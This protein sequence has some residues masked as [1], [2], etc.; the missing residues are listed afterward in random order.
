MYDS[1]K[2][3]KK[4]VD[5]MK[6]S[7]TSAL[8]VAV[9]TANV[10]IQ[11]FAEDIMLNDNQEI[12][13]ERI[14][15]KKGDLEID[16]N[17]ELPVKNVSIS[18]TNIKVQ[19]KKDDNVITEILLGSGSSRG[20]FEYDNAVYNY[21]INRLNFDR[22]SEVSENNKVYNYRIC[23]KDLP[24][25]ESISYG[26]EVIGNGFKTAKIDNIELNNY[27]KRVIMSNI[28][29]EDKNGALLFGD[30]NGDGIVNEDDYNELYSNLKTNKSK[31]DL[32]RDGKVNVT[33]LSYIHKNMNNQ[34]GESSIEDTNAI[35]DIENIEV[36]VSDGATVGQTITGNAEDLFNDNGTV[37][38]QMPED[39]TI[40]EETPAKL[41][42]DLGVKHK[43]DV[44]MEQI[45][46]KGGTNAPRTGSVE[47]NGQIYEFGKEQTT[48]STTGSSD[49]VIDLNGQIPVSKITINVTG[50]T[51]D[52]NLVDIAKVE[53]LNN[54]YKEIPKPEMALPVIN[55]VVTSTQVAHE[56]MEIT[57][58]RVQNVTGY[59]VK[60]ETIND[61]GVVQNTR[62]FRTSEERLTVR[63]IKAYG[64]YRIS[65]QSLNG[66]WQGGYK[67][68]EPDDVDG[69]PDNIVKESIASGTYQIKPIERDSIVEI[70]VVPESKPD[71]PEGIVVESGYK[72]LDVSW[73]SHNSAQSFDVYYR[74][75]GENEA[76]DFTKAN[77]KPI[78]NTTKYTIGGLKDGVSYEVKMTATNHLGTS[79]MSKGYV[80]KTTEM[81]IPKSPNYKLINTPTGENT[82]TSHI[83]SVEFPITAGEGNTD[84]FDE[85]CVV[86]NDY[87]TAWT[88]NDWDA[89]IYNKRGP[90]VT[91]DKEYE[92]DTIALIARLDSV[93]SNPYKA[94]IGVWNDQTNEWE[95][96]E[97]SVINK[98]ENG[99]YTILK[100]DKPITGKKIQVNT[101]VYGTNKVS[102]A[103]IKFYNYDSVEHDIKALF[104]D[105]LQIELRKSTNVTQSEIDNLRERLN[106]V[107]P[108]SKEYHPDRDTLLKELQLAEDLL[109]DKE[110]SEKVITIDPLINKSGV[111]TGYNN[112]WQA[113][114][115]SAKAGDTINVYLAS[116]ENRNIN[117]AYEQH[118]GESG[119]FISKEI[120]LK[121]GKNTIQL[122]KLHDINVEKGGNLYVRYPRNVENSNAQ[123]KIR[124]SGATQIPHLNL[125]NHLEDVNTLVNNKDNAS[126]EKVAEI[127]AMLKEYIE[128][129]KV[130]VNGL[131]DMY[132]KNATSVDNLNNVYSYDEKT[133][134]L[135]TTNIEGDR[136]TLTL[137]ATEV[138]EGITKDIEGDI[139][140][141]VD[142]L[143]DTVLAWEQIIQVTN[144]KKGVYERLNDFNGSGEIDDDD[145]A[146]YNSNK[147]SKSRVNVKYQRMFI[148]AFMYASGHHIGVDTGSSVGL[149]QGVPFK[150]DENGK[151]TNPDEGKLFGW[152]ISHEIGHK[153]DTPGRVYNET[154]NNILALI[155]QT[156]DGIDKSR[157][158]ENDTYKKIYER[159]TSGSVGTPQDISVL[160]GMFW[161]LHLAYEPG[162][163]SQMLINNSDNNPDNDSFY[164]KLNRAYRNTPA[165][166]SDKDQLLIRRASDAAGKDLRGFFASWGLIADESTSIYLQQKFPNKKETR[167]IQYLNDN[168]YRKRLDGV[169]SIASDTEVEASFVGT[170]NNSVVNSD[171]IT[172]DLNVN[173]DKDKILG[174]EII[175]SDGNYNEDGKTKVS[176]K[177]V[178]FVEA[179]EDGSATFT[180]SIAPLNNRALTYKVIAYDYNLNPTAEYEVGSVKLSHDGR[181][182]SNKFILKSNLTS[183]IEDMTLDN[184]KDGDNTTSFKGR[185]ITKD[186]YNNDPHKEEGIDVNADPYIIMDLNGSKDICGIKYI[187]SDDSVSKFSLKKL[188]ARNSSYSAIDK[189]EIH[190]SDD[191]KTWTKVSEGSFNFGENSVL[192]GANGE[193]IAKVLF[194]NGTDLITYNTKYVKLVA[195]G[196][197]NIDIADIEL[198]GGTGD[199]IEIGA[200][201]S[202]DNTRTNG[203][204]RLDKEFV[205]Q[206]DNEETTDTDEEIVIPEG[207]IV[208]TGEYKGNP[209]FNIPLLIDEKNNTI[210]GE[211]ILMANV[212]EDAPL[213]SVS[214]GKW[215]YWLSEDEYD[216]LTNKVKAELY[217]YNELVDDAPIGQRLVSDTLYVDVPGD[218]YNELPSISLEN[219]GVYVK[220]KSINTTKVIYMDSKE[221]EAIKETLR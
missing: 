55:N 53:F 10:P 84:I 194:S 137:P 4:G 39:V 168:A 214:S 32:N 151:V 154:T 169:E 129:L 156:F 188:F 54:V 49:I 148:G 114:G 125:N 14:N 74:E 160:L 198:I 94:N 208:I 27:S 138:Y 90:I 186:E 124:V 100:L 115:F 166:T 50:T 183:D 159:V 209:A 185:K 9:V 117:L 68:A 44:V 131:P 21:T 97:A 176:Y 161:Q 40:S 89:S 5:Y 197:K 47:V 157:L 88:I 192:G 58:D 195:V 52:R 163:T 153:A 135:N 101:S 179:K 216:S 41:D 48:R 220:S 7:I 62:T 177:P 70:M 43:K 171:S 12:V 36:K 111:N 59:E 170:E 112:D 37:V 23:F 24:A 207:S 99:A 28:K 61:K 63:D 221:L 187:K 180:D 213:G 126:D 66:E 2:L 67:V 42:I 85:D 200:I 218:T 20:S 82:L 93:G 106:T 3:T 182:D 162:A 17:F 206:A 29:S 199:N 19:L 31:Y 132:K 142:R 210:N 116:S 95:Y 11:T 204:G 201:N 25:G 56:K 18:D 77:E 71:A 81:R 145:R 30:L 121:P 110:V 134:I 165:E 96:H 104:N 190:I 35:L 174:Y 147:A 118:Y 205:V 146:E 16:V 13:T 83:E 60:V 98:N 102:I 189:Y 128:T 72:M 79:G 193:N 105:D 34:Q 175:R 164:A 64:R 15:S 119:K 127:K 191:S 120:T 38:L 196:A 133:S 141:Q 91:F 144:A 75:L 92:I 172:L 46:I 113:L 122:E 167:K 181:I 109:N 108:V 69:I 6:K 212:P 57:W 184:I 152:G 211:V 45:V 123:I 8:T 178:G 158:E 150:F 173:K 139:N 65:I 73:K 203:I 86:D 215:I 1:T 80:G 51:N 155:T 217:R 26:L 219:G 22:S 202:L 136:F 140:A 143:Y 149:M 130:H 78:T 76:K 103:E 87:S 107:D 33:D